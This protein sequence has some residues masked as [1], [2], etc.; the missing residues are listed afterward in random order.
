MDHEQIL[1]AHPNG[2]SKIRLE[3]RR[4]FI[5]CIGITHPNHTTWDGQSLEY[6]SEMDYVFTR[7][8]GKGYL[9]S[10]LPTESSIELKE[11]GL[12]APDNEMQSHVKMVTF[13]CRISTF[14]IQ[15]K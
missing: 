14:V 8:N 5:H 13:E 7:L 10:K 12:S 4:G 1:P 2:Q 11:V 15:P 6:V 9:V 3:Q